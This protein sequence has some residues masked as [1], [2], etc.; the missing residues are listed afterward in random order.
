MRD[1]LTVTNLPIA[2]DVEEM[3][4][5]LVAMIEQKVWF[6]NYE[7]SHLYDKKQP[8]YSAQLKDFL[9]KMGSDI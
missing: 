8:T 9:I 1:L 7:M 2:N 3:L 5:L 4:K 6:V